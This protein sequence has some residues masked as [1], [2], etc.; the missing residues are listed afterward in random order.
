LEVFQNAVGK[1]IDPFESGND[2]GRMVCSL[3]TLG[4]AYC[5]DDPF[6]V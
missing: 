5:L 1:L 3:T 4:E 2:L 6:M